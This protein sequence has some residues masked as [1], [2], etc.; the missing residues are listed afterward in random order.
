MV[1]I[2]PVPQTCNPD[3]ALAD[4]SERDACWDRHRRNADT[5]QLYYGRNAKATRLAECAQDLGFLLV[6]DSELGEYQLRLHIAHF[7][8]VRYCTVCQ[9]RRSLRWKAKAHEVFPQIVRDY[10]TARFLFLTLAPRN[11]K[12]ENLRETLTLMNKSFAK[13]SRYKRWPAIG[14]LRSTEVIR[15]RDG[16][17]AHPHFHCLLMVKHSYFRGKTYIN[18]DDWLAMWQKALK[19]DYKP[20]VHITAMREKVNPTDL[21]PELLKYSTKESDLIADKD[22]FWELMKQTHKMRFVSTSGIIKQYLSSLEEEP[23][24][25]IGEGDDGRPDEGK[26]FFS[27]R[28]EEKRY[29]YRETARELERER[30]RDTARD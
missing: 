13:L 18:H 9:W 21:I 16:V 29:R 23:D 5:I 24:D 19:V 11:C 28:K 20:H 26:L 15:G 10:P 12:I 7:C 6:P 1:N 4:L 22:W 27:W 30:E 3:I 2:A 8:R 17:S 25:L 14:W